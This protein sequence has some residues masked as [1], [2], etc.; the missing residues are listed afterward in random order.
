MKRVLLAT[1]I[2]LA[3]AGCTSTQ[4][5]E[6]VGGGEVVGT[7]GARQIVDGVDIWEEG[8]PPVKYKVIG[9]IDD[10]RS[11]GP[12][13]RAQR[14]PSIAKAVKEHGG[15]AAIILKEGREFAGM[16]MNSTTAAYG[17]GSYANANTTGFATPMMHVNTKAAVI[18]YVSSQ[19]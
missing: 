9:I 16:V 18:K 15:D 6:Y 12:I 13:H 5:K 11:N 19:N 2:A 14:L 3:V 1:A 8:T 7:G 4:F 10:N 17:H